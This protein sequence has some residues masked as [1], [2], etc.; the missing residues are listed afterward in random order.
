MDLLS[1]IAAGAVLFMIGA[2]TAILLL[3]AY[4]SL[5]NPVL[6]KIGLRNLVRRPAQSILIVV[7]MTLS[8]I[9]IIS[10]FGTGDTLNYSVQRQA[11]A[12]YGEVDEI[13]APPLLSLLATME[14][15]NGNE[16]AV[17]ELEETVGSLTAGGLETVLTLVQGGLPSLDIE[18]LE[19]LRAEAEADPLIDGVSGAIVFPTILRN[20]STGA[21]EPL[22]VI[23]AVDD[24]YPETFGLV[25]VDGRPLDMTGLQPGIGNIFLQASDLFSLVS[26]QIGRLTGDDASLAAQAIAGLGALFTGVATDQLP[27]LS[28]DLAT[29]EELG[30]DTAPLEAMGIETLDLETIATA[31]GM[32]DE[33]ADEISGTVQDSLRAVSDSA[34]QLLAVVNLNTL[35]YE[36]D[37]V[38]GQYGLQ[39]RQGDLYLSRLAADRLGANAGDVVEVYVGPLPVRFRVKAVV[40]QAG[41]LSAL[42]PVVML[43]LEE[44]QQ[45][46]FMNDKVNTVLVSNLGDE[47]SG[48]EHSEEVTQR[49]S[50][51]AMDPAAVDKINEILARPDVGPI[52]A[53]SAPDLLTDTSMQADEGAPPLVASLVETIGQSLG[54][55]TATEEEVDLL[56]AAAAGDTSADLRK[57]LVNTNLRTWLLDLDLPEAARDELQDALANLNTFDVI[58]PL[59]KSTIVAAATVGG[60][61]FS[62]VFSL[63]GG[64]SI[65]AA[66]LLIFLIFVMLAAERRSEIGLARA[67]GTQRRQVVQIF[68]TEGM[69]YALAASALGVLIGIGVT[70]AMT[71][72]IGRLFNDFTGQVNPQAAG[73]FGITF[74][75][76]WQSIVI[77]YCLGVVLTFVVIVVASYRV[78]NMNIVSAIRNLPDRGG[79]RSR[80]GLRGVWRW[81][82][83]VLVTAGGVGLLVWTTPDGSYSLALLGVT[84]LLIGGMLLLGRLLERTRVRRATVERLVYT[85]I[86]LGLLALWTLP[87]GRWLPQAAPDLYS[88]NQIQLPI[89]FLAG[90]ILIVVGA[91]MVIMVNADALGWLAS[92]ALGF[93]PWMRPVLKTAIAYPLNTRFRTGM[94]MVLFAMIMAS[95]V[96]MAVVIHATQTLVQ[97]DEKSTAGFDIEVS[98]TLLSFFS[99][100]DDFAAALEEQADAE[101]LADVAAVG[102]VYRDVVR[103]R[104]DDGRWLYAGINGL[105]QGYVDQAEGVYSFQARAPGYDSD[106]AVWQ[107][108]RADEDVAI[109]LPAK[110]GEGRRMSFEVDADEGDEFGPGGR[111]DERHNM[112]RNEL[113]FSDV[114]IE[115]GRLPELYVEVKADVDAS[116]EAPPPRKLQVIAVLEEDEA[117][118]WSGVQTGATVLSTVLGDTPQD[119]N[120]YVKV[121]EGADVH[122]VAQGVERAFVPNG[123]DAVVLAERFMQGQQL[124]SGILRL[125]QGFMALGLLVGIAALGVVSTR[126]VVERRQQVGML[127]AI[128]YQ[129]QMVGLSFVLESSFISLSGLLIGSL[130]GIVL[131]GLVLQS[132]FPE[133][134]DG[135]AAATPWL[136]I[137]AIVIAAYL[138]SLL[139]TIVPVW[140]ASRIYPAEALRYE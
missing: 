53:E 100:V 68:V 72:F 124:M 21:G 114:S 91:I 42:V 30:V 64:L 40:D 107:A 14:S 133:V 104:T 23:Y 121:R 116:E 24:Q 110:L 111:R 17:S 27:D 20:T 96:V 73:L 45:L 61:V 51:L 36:I 136:T 39:L 106:A 25:S 137:I 75:I 119:V 132:S 19:A 88:Y 22:G 54:I 56:L 84:L 83:P 97:L 86:G 43:P 46:L 38:L 62:S 138:F 109:I 2:V 3:L 80:K 98:P 127:R 77:S 67:V 128:G 6:M 126:A 82:L 95:V 78:S 140:Q 122:T 117:L 11:V 41:P 101:V 58:L 115:G 135:S 13:I 48:L 87:W 92:H 31:L 33:Q 71:R 105:N 118:A 81:L 50:V 89:L 131:G 60:T 59:S 70:L 37:R 90:A 15:G 63:F 55:R 69:V 7:G 8:T 34:N 139:T 1:N 10:A 76:N 49:L 74:H 29:L 108:L 103:A 47:L 125:L 134:A 32:S 4:L 123:L 57:A 112:M 79:M 102:Q 44:A 26:N 120:N 9:I 129:K 65:L 18:R 35:G 12:A 5:R 16:E 85:V 113:F 93:I 52:V 94:T 66:I 99:P 28:L 130:T